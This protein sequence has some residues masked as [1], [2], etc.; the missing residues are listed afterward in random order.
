MLLCLNRSLNNLYIICTSLTNANN[1]GNENIIE[2][3][4]LTVHNITE[5]EVR[6]EAQL[7]RHHDH[8]KDILGDSLR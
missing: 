3:A 5:I 4:L 6:E 1:K 7:K 2:T 8:V